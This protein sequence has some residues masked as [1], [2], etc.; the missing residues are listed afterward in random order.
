MQKLYPA[1][2]LHCGIENSIVPWLAGMSQFQRDDQSGYE[3]PTEEN[4]YVEI[5]WCFSGVYY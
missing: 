4:F 5:Y 1:Y 2:Q 3:L